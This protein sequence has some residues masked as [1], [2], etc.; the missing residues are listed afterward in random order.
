M[1]RWYIE[2]KAGESWRDLSH[3]FGGSIP[4][5]K[6]LGDFGWHEGD[7][8]RVEGRTLCCFDFPDRYGNKIALFEAWAKG[9]G[10]LYG[11]ARDGKVRFPGAPGL[12]ATLPPEPS[13]PVPAWLR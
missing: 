1:A 10:R 7:P 12:V 5:P 11:E 13:A 6:D 2:A 9:T 4:N 3:Q 8:V